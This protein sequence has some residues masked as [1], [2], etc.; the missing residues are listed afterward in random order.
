M[1]LMLRFAMEPTLIVVFLFV[2]VII[3]IQNKAKERQNRLK[4]LEEA[5]KNGNLDENTRQELVNAL[6]DRPVHRKRSE[7]AAA[8]PQPT[9]TAPAE[10]PKRS[11]GARF[12]FAIGWLALFTGIALI[13][14]DDHDTWEAGIMVA[15]SGFALMSLPIAVREL[16]REKPEKSSRRA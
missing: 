2:V 4:V 3:L 7:P 11:G 8:T 12:L 10:A 14:M 9:P 16:D 5:L 1:L 13:A 15:F 6:S